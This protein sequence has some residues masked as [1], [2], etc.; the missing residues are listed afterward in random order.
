[1]NELTIRFGQE[2]IQLLIAY[3]IKNYMDFDDFCEFTEYENAVPVDVE[4]CVECHK[5]SYYDEG[6]PTYAC[7]NFKKI[8]LFR[9]LAAQFAQVS[10]VLRGHLP[11]F[12]EETSNLS[13]ISLGGGPAPEAIALM[14]GLNS[15]KEKFK[16]Y[17]DNVDSEASWDA[18]YNNI[19]HEF[20]NYITN[21]ELHTGFIC[22]DI[23]NYVSE[24]KY[25]IAFISWVLSEMNE[26]DR[27]RVIKVVRD[28]VIPEGYII[29][30]G[31]LGNSG[32]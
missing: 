7:D 15:S 10:F 30:N 1:M 26:R 14:N 32:G 2:P 20:E 8:Y 25:D 4:E 22:S 17:F 5:D 23:T 13:A 21:L 11:R 12:L 24:K 29:K 9:Y 18:I 28:L 6:E 3:I 31:S 16:L 27:D 19:L